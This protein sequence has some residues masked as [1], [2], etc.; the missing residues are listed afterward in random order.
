MPLQSCGE[1][2]SYE[3][4]HCVMTEAMGR[5]D[6]RHISRRSSLGS[7]SG[8]SLLLSSSSAGS[9]FSKACF[10]ICAV[11]SKCDMEAVG[12]WRK[13]RMCYCSDPGNMADTPVFLLDA[14]CAPMVHVWP[15]WWPRSLCLFTQMLKVLMLKTLKFHFVRLWSVRHSTEVCVHESGW[16]HSS[17]W[18]PP[19]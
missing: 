10:P 2:W 17:F 6:H 9:S 16:R 12:S 7:I 8:E 13:G 11:T 19:T 3:L 14:L 15:F 1:K 5:N 4:L 18:L